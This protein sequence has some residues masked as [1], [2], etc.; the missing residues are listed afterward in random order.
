MQFSTKAEYSLRAMI[1]L[2]RSYPAQRNIKEISETE[3][4]SPKYLEKLVGLL[5]K[6]GLVE[7]QKGKNGGYVLSRKPE[8]ISAGEIIEIV[9][10]PIVSKCTDTHCAKLAKC[11]SSQVWNKLAIQIKKTLYAIKLIDLI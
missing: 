5:R 3:N 8:L 6:S 11:T 4:I 9:E 1:D 7:S 2:A 10:G